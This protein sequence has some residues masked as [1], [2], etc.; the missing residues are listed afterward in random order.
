MARRVSWLHLSD[1]H[2][3]A[4]DAWRDSAARGSLLEFLE[5]EMGES[6]P[7]PDLILCT[8][9]IAFGELR[10][11]SLAHQYEEAREF[12]SR[13]MNLA[14]NV[15]PEL[16]Y[17]RLF[18]VP[19]NHDVD[20]SAVN[21]DAQLYLVGLAR[22]SRRHVDDINRRLADGS[23]AYRDTLKRLA[24][25]RE[26]AMSMCPH[27]KWDDQHLHYAHSLTIHDVPVQIVGLNSA[28]GCSGDEEERRL[29]IG[30]KAQLACVKRETSLRIGL[31]HH[32]L[33]WMTRPD[34]QFLEQRMGSDLHFLLH[35]HE[36]EYREVAMHGDFPVIGTGAVSAESKD[37][38]GVLMVQLDLDAG[39]QERYVLLYD[40]NRGTWHRSERDTRNDH[41]LPDRILAHVIGPRRIVGPKVPESRRKYGAYFSREGRF[42]SHEAYDDRIER[43]SGTLNRDSVYFR[44][45][46]RDC[47]NHHCVNQMAGDPEKL[48]LLKGDASR[49]IAKD[50]ID[51]YFVR[52]IMETPLMASTANEDADDRNDTKI[53]FDEF[54][55]MVSDTPI[56]G[57]DGAPPGE[58]R[59]SYLLG[60]AGVGKTLTV[61]KLCDVLRS[62]PV[63]ASG[64]RA[65]PV[66]KDLHQERSWNES[67]PEIA[68]AKSLQALGQEFL[69]ELKA[70]KFDTPPELRF[71]SLDTAEAELKKLCEV[72]AKRKHYPV[73]VLDNGDR[74][75]F[76]N[77]RYRFFPEYARSHQWRLEDTLI[78]L[79]DRFVAEHALGKTAACVLLVC[80]K[81][82]Y[83]HCRRAS[84]AADPHG[85]VRRDHRVF[86]VQPIPVGRIIASRLKMFEDCLAVLEG[87]Y[88]NAAMFRERFEAIERRLASWG[89]G[90]DNEADSDALL[91]IIC[92]LA[93]QG[94][95]SF[96][97]FLSALPVDVRR[98]STLVERLFKQPYVLLR[99]YMS[100]MYKRYTERQGHFPNLFLNDCV[101]DPNK[102]YDRA[103]FAHVH[104]YWLRYLILRF[105]CAHDGHTCHSERIVEFFTGSLGYEEHLVRLSLGF[106]SD[107]NSSSCLDIV[108]PD[109][110]KR[111]EE[112]LRVS[113]RGALL[114]N[115]RGN[116][117]PLCFS[118]DYLQ[119]VT[120]DYLLA[121]PST[122]AR[123]I[124][125]DAD[126]GHT[127][128]DGH[129]YARGSRQVLA[130]KIPAVI[131]FFMVLEASF[132]AEMGHR[133]AEDAV[134]KLAP[135]F[136]LIGEQLMTSIE[137]VLVKFDDMGSM[138]Q[139]SP[140]R[141]IWND[142]ALRTS[143]RKAVDAYYDSPA[144]V[145]L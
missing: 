41:R 11:Q 57:K 1:I 139:S 145:T 36:H 102:L 131:R 96:L 112:I 17:T 65:V 9:D 3:C 82:V 137:K 101:I 43:S 10:T 58:N 33:E 90:K 88:T 80:R 51:A 38:H 135:D 14:R 25:Y 52:Q 20:R 125:V 119:L 72:A 8:G 123:D 89:K 60:S 7:V 48:H 127:L 98:D 91:V 118:F 140:P 32:P 99:I 138:L 2:F 114:V 45:M 46:W 39:T 142:Q 22:D 18:M 5:A 16:D 69:R 136:K 64:D 75:F 124:F 55:K 129:E 122:V 93:H 111:N 27:I 103:H 94:H 34:S 106:L 68:L 105:V 21:T 42:G 4:R 37:E 87:T 63:E 70:C 115:E 67:S 62:A 76:E 109:R 23:P 53:S 79:I 144:Q 104:T 30:T 133:Q 71:E 95:R 84:D 50:N 86:Q 130:A 13:V 77:A 110:I 12:I 141:N 19:G 26:F 54:V 24:A 108:M 116:R 92:D 66:Y 35:G 49:L 28:W 61:L 44:T 134:A 56:T 128:K 59:I 83:S 81:Y 73:F 120:D 121:M 107:P 85:P 132:R 100:N 113:S 15:S 6:L 126:L 78:A 47:C 29:W 117:E 40:P 143:I 97:N 31:V 74:F